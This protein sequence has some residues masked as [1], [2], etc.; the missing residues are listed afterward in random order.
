MPVVFPGFSWHNMYGGPS[1]QIPRLRGQFLWS[2][3]CE[4][5]RANAPMV[6]VAMFDEVDEGTAIFKCANEVPEGEKSQFVTYEGLPS[7]FYLKMVGEG[8]EL[9]RGER[10]LSDENL[11]GLRATAE[12]RT[13]Q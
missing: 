1:A 8:A 11:S 6:Y 12:S 10:K 3:F 5:K 4:A 9:I 13:T 7:D 2:Q